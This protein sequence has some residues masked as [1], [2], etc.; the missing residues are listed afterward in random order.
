MVAIVGYIDK[1]R[2]LIPEK[3]QIIFQGFVTKKGPYREID[4]RGRDPGGWYYGVYIRHTWFYTRRYHCGW[5]VDT[6]RVFGFLAAD[7]LWTKGSGAVHLCS[8]SRARTRGRGHYRIDL[9]KS[10][11]AKFSNGLEKFTKQILEHFKLS[12]TKIEWDM[13]RQGGCW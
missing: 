1:R 12:S 5:S 9:N 7:N 13:F 4:R 10:F 8:V 3:G 6:T 11:K 2:S